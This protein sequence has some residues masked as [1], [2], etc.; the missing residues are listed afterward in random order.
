MS[1]QLRN[2]E[3]DPDLFELLAGISIFCPNVQGTS[4]LLTVDMQNSNNLY[5]Y[6]TLLAV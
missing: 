4:M 5:E 6:F 3:H 1:G 2:A